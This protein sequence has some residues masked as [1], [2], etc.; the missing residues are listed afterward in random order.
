MNR[1]SMP[2]IL[3]LVAGAITCII[4]LINDYTILERLIALFVVLVVFYLLGNALKWTLDYFDSENER[5]RLEEEEAENES[6]ITEEEQ[7]KQET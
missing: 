4:T 2:L 7:G 3:M 6:E 5:K 1:K